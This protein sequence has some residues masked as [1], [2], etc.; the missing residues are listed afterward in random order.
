MRKISLVL[1]SIVISVSGWCQKTGLFED[2]GVIVGP[3]MSHVLGGESWKPTIGF[4]LGAETNV[5]DLSENSSVRA[6][7]IFSI[8]GAS[9][10][11]SYSTDPYTYSLKSALADDMEFSGKVTLSYINVPV[12][13]HY[14]SNNGVYLEGGIQPAFLISAKDKPED[15]ASYDYKDYIKTI[16]VG[17]P[18]GI[19]YWLNDR[20]S[21]GARIVF[22]LTNINT[23]GT[24]MYTSDDNDRNFMLMGVVR[25]KLNKD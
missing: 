14:Q 1:I 9:Y 18:L 16:D 2:F 10:T 22:G 13:F 5:Y 17:I 25:L 7:V 3:G 4:L 15:G 11:E 6:G 24:E 8:Q 12:L 23:E 19:G 21:A 20:I